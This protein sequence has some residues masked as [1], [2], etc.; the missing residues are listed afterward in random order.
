MVQ[1]IAGK[2]GKGKTKQLLDKVNADVLTANGNIV[3]ID[4]STKHMF[5]LNNKVRLIDVSEFPI[6]NYDQFIRFI[7]GIASQDHDLE[8][9]YLD[10]SITVSCVTEEYLGFVLSKLSDI[11]SRFNVN[12][13]SES[14][15][16]GTPIAPVFFT[17]SKRGSVSRNFKNLFK[18]VVLSENSIYI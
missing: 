11:S 8:S 12:V 16:H 1:I 2:K 3:Y 14:L 9:M 18:L 4:K 7:L 10:S 17:S 5:E 6:D 13:P 15:K